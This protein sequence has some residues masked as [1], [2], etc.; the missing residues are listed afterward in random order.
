MASTTI[1]R[2]G[3]DRSAFTCTCFV[4]I[5]LPAFPRGRF[6]LCISTSTPR[7][8][9]GGNLVRHVPTTKSRVSW[10]FSFARFHVHH[11][12]LLS[13]AMACTRHAAHHR[14]R[15]V[16]DRVVKKTRMT[17][18]LC[19]DMNHEH[20]NGLPHDHHKDTCKGGRK[21]VP[22]QSTSNA[23]AIRRGKRKQATQTHQGDK[24]RRV[25]GCISMDGTNK[26]K[27]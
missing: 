15:L 18:M 21:Q 23:N 4:R 10:T 7:P 26:T 11:A 6:V 17:Q 5:D 2:H 12:P 14:P 16:V 22:T 25:P 3:Q 19:G 20:G 13:F 1:H 24:E 9:V 8:R 27:P